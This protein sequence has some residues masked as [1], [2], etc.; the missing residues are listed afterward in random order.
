[1]LASATL[2]LAVI[3]S[4]TVVDAA[5]HRPIEGARVAIPFLTREAATADS[6]RFAFEVAPGR[7]DIY[8]RAEG[9]EEL[10]A[11]DVP[12]P[13]AGRRD[14]LLQL[15]PALEPGEFGNTVYRMDRVNVTASRMEGRTT[16]TP[17]EIHVIEGDRTRQRLANGTPE[18]LA[19]LP[20]V[21][22]QKTSLGGGAPIM[23]GLSGNRVLLL[24]DGVRL[25]NS[26]YRI[27]LNQYLNTVDPGLIRRIE[28][29][30]GAGS[31]LYGSDAL[32]GV[33]QVLTAEPEPD[34]ARV[35][36]SGQI[37]AAE[38]STTHHLR[39]GRWRGDMGILLSGGLRDL[40]HLRAGGGVGIQKPTAYS[41][42][43]G[44]GRWLW[45]LPSGADLSAGYQITR[46]DDVPRT[47]R[48]AAGRDSLYLYDPQHRELAFLRY[49]A[50]SP[51]RWLE[52]LRVTASWNHQREGRRIIRLPEPE[53]R[54]EFM[55]DVQTF[56]LTGEGRSLIGTRSLLIYGADLYHDLVDSRGRY[57]HLRTG[58]VRDT[59][60]K[61]PDDGRHTSIG[62][63]LQAEHDLNARW[64]VIGALRFS[65]FHLEGTPQGEFG[66]VRADNQVLTGSLQLRRELGGAGRLFAGL[67]QSF[68][69][70]NM[71]DALSSGLSNKGYDVPNPGLRPETGWHL[72]LGWRGRSGPDAAFDLEGE[73]VV[74]AARID[75]L[76][77]RAPATHLGAD[78]LD[79][80]PVFHNE[81]LG[82]AA[83]TGVSFAGR[84][85]WSRSWSARLSGAWTYGENIDLDVPLTRIP[86]L[87]GAVSLR[88]SRPWGW[89]G[90]ELEWARR[91]SRLSPDDRRDTRIPAGG[92][93]GYAIV[94]LR[95]AYRLREGLVIRWAL[96]NLLDDAYR[97]H[98]SG[99]DSPGR[100]L[101]LGLEW[102]LR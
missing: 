64:N 71:E 57:V 95:G 99:I 96:L 75:D 44:A 45:R 17:R 91:Q 92:T 37:T 80:A 90:S 36:Y 82:R 76:I 87:R 47:D 24:V 70:P 12:V 16:R 9:Y 81:N 89:L 52:R 8:V 41:E 1:M 94:H 72:E 48:M 56:G 61:L 19:A 53:E 77:E 79:G 83:L 13:A 40:N 20:Q 98:G 55:D 28:V 88:R 46:Q 14:L 34:M 2:T 102:S 15:R 68:R 51:A 69:S 3:L 93:P 58:A 11:L 30:P 59:A 32:G 5:S 10:R 22:V 33:I 50:P 100:N 42:W 101:I 63:F 84:L 60:G 49:T 35:S 4:G 74:F 78:S 31:V 26:T 65:S 86:P 97:I 18:A 21:L 66:K 27:G 54:Q 6:G 23:R 25:N 43:S 38:G 39:A 29:V 73:A 85:A 7:Y 62:L 67:Q